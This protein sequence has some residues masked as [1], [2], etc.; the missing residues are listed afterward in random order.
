MLP[1]PARFTRLFRS[2]ASSAQRQADQLAR[3]TAQLNFAHKLAAIHPDR[4]TE[5]QS[6]ILKAGRVAQAGLQANQIDLDAL[7][8]QAENILA[9]IGLVAKTY[10]LLCISHAHIDMNW[11]WSWPETVAVTND[12]FQTMLTLMDEFPGWIY[13]QSQASTYQLIEKYNPAM[14]EQIRRRIDQ[15]RWEVTASQWVEG[16]KNMANGESISRHLLYTREYMWKTFGL[17]PQDVTV[18]FEPDTFGHPATLP[19][20]LARGG[21]KYYYHCRGSVG[22]HLYW[23]LG[24]DG[25]RLLTF[26]DVQWYMCTIGP[27]IADALPEFSLATGMKAMPVLYGVGDHGGGPTR[28]DLKRVIEMNNWPVFPNLEFSTLHNFFRRAEKEATNVPEISGE[29]NCVFDGCYTSQARQKWANRRSE[30]SLFAAEAAAVIGSRIA[31][32]PYPQENLDQAWKHVLFDQFHDILPGSGVRET[33][34]YAMARAQDSQAASSMAR[35]NALRALSRQIDTASLRDAFAPDGERQDEAESALSMGAGAGYATGTGGESAF[36]V[37][38][39]SDRAFLIFNPLPHPRREVIEAKLWDANLDEKQLVVTGENA[40]PQPVQV[41]DKGKYWGH[42]FSTIAFPVQIPALGYRAVCISDRRAE[43]GPPTSDPA[44]PWGGMVVSW[45]KIQPNDW[46]LENEYLRLEIDPA[47]G[48]LSSLIDKRSGREW[49]PDGEL[50]GVLR[51]SVEQNRGMTAWVIGQFLTQEDLIDGGAL[52]KI[53]SGPY[54]NTWR[55]SKTIHHSKLEL[56]ITLRAGVPRVEYRLRVDWREMG[57]AD[58]IPNLRARF[59]LAIDR[60]QPRYEIPFGSIRRDLFDGEE[61]PA[62]RW[63]DLSSPDGA[64]ITLVNSSKYG[65]GMQGNALSMTLLRASIDPDPLPDLGEHIIEYALLPHGD[66][67]SVGQ[68]MRA[69]AEINIPLVVSS[70][71]FHPGKL[72]SAASLVEIHDQNVHLAA[73]KESQEN[74]QLPG[75]KAIVLRLIE[76]EGR[77]TEARVSIAPEL[78]PDGA[79]VIEVDTLEQPVESN[80]ARWENHTLRVTL[81]AFGIVTVLGIQ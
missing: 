74:D 80:T 14:F 13:S 76:V 55:W 27:Q 51:Y 67:W 64:G 12:T 18:D 77:D 29:R 15:G 45:R 66:E 53:R 32:V 50:I 11:M 43:L 2:F 20:I 34:H 19:T 6:L 56:D 41:L 39:S 71:D 31:G 17:T 65:F 1:Y 78:L 52:E 79:T 42:E 61:T 70:C 22:P 47:S 8:A 68:A 38:R 57:S 69:G 33:R 62:Q 21:V 37:A 72:P 5:W 63:V 48:G 54:I 9:P 73:L 23:W 59:P 28:R 35:T 75:G 36:S 81:P 25:S 16:D 24:P 49:A 7:I 44:D 46:S 58:G 3:L 30:N 10:T 26:N 4:A 60:P 40:A